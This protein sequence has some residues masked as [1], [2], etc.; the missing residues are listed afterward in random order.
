MTNLI[1]V[2]LGLCSDG[3]DEHVLFGVD[4]IVTM[5]KFLQEKLSKV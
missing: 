1:V 4:A 5:E 2:L 3:S